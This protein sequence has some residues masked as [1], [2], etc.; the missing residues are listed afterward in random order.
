MS[1]HPG[2]GLRAP[3]TLWA[4]A[5]AL[6]VFVALVV[7]A[8][9]LGEY[10]LDHGHR[11]RILA[12]PLIGSFDPSLSWRWLPAGLFAVAAI[13]WF[14]AWAA[15]APW[16]RLLAA[17]ALGL[18]AW[19][20]AL[21]FSRSGWHEI[22]RPMALPGHYLEGVVAVGSPGD[23]LRH[24]VDRIDQYGTH[25]RAH[26]PGFVLVLWV[27]DRI[28]LGGAQWAGAL[29]IVGGALAVPAVMIAI[30]DLADER[31]ARLAAPWLMVA[32]AALY[33][34]STADAFF[35][36][37]TAWSCALIVLA[38]C[39]ASGTAAS[40]TAARRRGLAFGGGLLFGVG[41]ML[42]YGMVL[43][44]LPLAA[45]LLGRRAW[46]VAV[47]AAAGAIAV[48]AAFASAGF[49]WWDGLHA[50]RREYRESVAMERPYW[51]FLVVNLAAFALIVGPAAAVALRTFRVRNPRHLSSVVA[52]GLTMVLAAAISG[53]S[54]GEVERIWLPFAFW[55][56][57]GAAVLVAHRSA[58]A[59]RWWL[60]AQCATAIAVQGLV[61]T[62]W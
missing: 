35:A 21:A 50:T 44:A 6:G 36:G 4:D 9:R 2:V 19:S 43:F 13:G 23:F 14:P 34:A 28:G 48:V 20:V 3:R 59:T 15:S 54:K 46:T 12:S 22:G 58:V 8:N 18:A 29:V 42:S 55:V 11:T 33:I 5:A 53:L 10:L 30:R 31:W 52:L 16:H 39:A 38:S 17:T 62:N 7:A 51:A 26:P 45:I 57:P 27:F 60:G 1:D 61:R 37:V 24:F 47:N 56:V 49:W 32:P 41:L 25:V 40:R